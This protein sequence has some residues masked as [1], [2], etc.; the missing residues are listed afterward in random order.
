MMD[1]REEFFRALH[2][3]P[4]WR[5]DELFVGDR[6]VAA[7]FG[8]S[9][10]AAYYLYSS[11]YDSELAE[12]SPGIVLLTHTIERL[13]AEGFTRFDFLKGD[14]EYKTRLGASYRQLYR[15]EA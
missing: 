9:D 12:V 3:E 7:L 2:S 13:A 1:A 5:V 10:G 14:E 8:F 4:G 11:A 6:A 15:I